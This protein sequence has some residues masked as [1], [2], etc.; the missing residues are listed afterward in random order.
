M[1][2]FPEN[3]GMSLV[4]QMLQNTVESD[5]ISEF[6]EEALLEI[7]NIIL[8]A[9]F[10]QLGNLLTTD[11]DGALPIY[12][13]ASAESILSEATVYVGD[14]KPSQTMLLQ[15]DFSLRNSQTK[16]FVLFTMDVNSLE[17]FKHKV[18]E[19]LHKIFG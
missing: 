14:A 8:N 4:R 11:L 5:N 17:T 12:L 6:E 9:C 18:D 3:G 13:R 1:L 19:Y 15:V 10:G 16:G 2:I 7:G